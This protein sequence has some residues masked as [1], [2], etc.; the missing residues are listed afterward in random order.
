MMAIIRNELELLDEVLA[1]FG[2]MQAFDQGLN[3]LWVLDRYVESDGMFPN[4]L[5]PHI[6]TRLASLPHFLVSF[7]KLHRQRNIISCDAVVLMRWT[8]T[9]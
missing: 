8:S 3:F 7:S 4:S 1:R 9:P 6:V 2:H 5:L